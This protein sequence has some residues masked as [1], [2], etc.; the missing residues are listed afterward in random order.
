[1][2]IGWID[3]SKDERSKVL[4]VID[5]LSEDGTLDE[6]GIAPIRDGF[7]NIFFPGTSTIQTRAKYFLI[8]PY[9]MA[10]LERSKESKPQVIMNKMDAIER[11]CGEVLLQTSDDGI[12]GSRNLKSGNW[13]KRTPANIYWA[14]IRKYGIFTGGTMSMPEYVRTSCALKMQKTTLKSLGNRRD[15]AEENN[16]DDADSGGLFSM[17]FWKLPDYDSENWV[18]SV[19][20]ELTE[21]ESQYLKTQILENC[22][23]SMMAFILKNDRRDIVE[24]D[25]FE[26]M[27]AGVITIFPQAIQEDYRLA[28]AFSDFI[29]GARIRYNIIL[30]Q[31]QNTAAISEWGIY[32]PN[33]AKYS[34]LDINTIFSRLKVYNPNLKSFLL[35]LQTNMK[36]GDIEAIDQCITKRECQ[37]KGASRAKLM[38]AG[39]FDVNNWIG[40]THLDYRFSSA[41]KIIK[42]IFD[43]EDNKN[44]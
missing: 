4:N 30:S 26:G 9:A 12:I 27:N 3:F 22:G 37:I 43:G 33:M 42:D 36:S 6:L 44:V 14:G 40:G 8:V 35:D 34:D 41:I 2:Q 28:K 18:E 16:R 21:T 15:E 31:G 29:Y 32:E 25:G 5:L 38:R 11:R 39:E 24:L 10:D 17:T 23:D 1:M 7:A 20:V 19:N 13:V